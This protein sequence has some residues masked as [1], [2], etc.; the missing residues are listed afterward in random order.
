MI[1]EMGFSI[2]V[3][4]THELKRILPEYSCFIR[5]IQ[6][7]EEK[8]LNARLSKHFISFSQRVYKSNDTGARMLDS[9]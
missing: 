1:A 4:N 8:R 6:R 7:V 2:C 3:P 5:F 9:I